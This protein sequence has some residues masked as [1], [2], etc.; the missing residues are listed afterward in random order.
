MIRSR[1][2]GDTITLAKRRCTKTLKKL[3]C[4]LKIPER[5]RGNIP[6]FVCGN[7]ILLVPGVGVGEKY[8]KTNETTQFMIIKTEV[9]K[10]DE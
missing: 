8:G 7:D 9:D 3:F 1:R 10:N 4:E 6:V 2:P 5:E